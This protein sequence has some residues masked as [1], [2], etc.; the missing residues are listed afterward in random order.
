MESVGLDLQ[1]FDGGGKQSLTWNWR[2]LTEA[3]NSH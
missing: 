3:A 2:S 1:E